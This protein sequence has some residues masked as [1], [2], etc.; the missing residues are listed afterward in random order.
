MRQ[1]DQ[2][3]RISRQQK[4]MA[5]KAAFGQGS[6]TRMVLGQNGSAAVGERRGSWTAEAGREV[7]A[8][9]SARIRRTSGEELATEEEWQPYRGF[10]LL[11]FM[12]SAMLLMV[13]I[14]AFHWGF[15]YEGFDRAYVQEKLNDETAWNHLEK[16]VQ[17][18]YLSLEKKWKK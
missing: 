11:R 5:A 10:G 14:A 7:G 15:S 1:E 6:T 12:T 2:E 17:Q 8:P 16:Q 18:V 3:P 9:A 13:L 4:V